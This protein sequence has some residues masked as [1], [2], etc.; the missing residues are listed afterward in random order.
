MLPPSKTVRVDSR[1]SVRTEAKRSLL[2][3]ENAIRARPSLPIRS[4]V[5]TAPGMRTDQN[6][7]PVSRPYETGPSPSL[8]TNVSWMTPSTTR[9]DC[10]RS[11]TSPIRIGADRAQDSRSPALD[12]YIMGGQPIR[13]PVVQHGPF[14]MNTRDE[15]VQAFADYQA[16]RLGSIPPDQIR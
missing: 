4:D 13:E 3:A 5:S 8:E 1:P 6:R 15:I 2:P 16:G 9:N 11:P 14:V 7:V 12:L 10:K